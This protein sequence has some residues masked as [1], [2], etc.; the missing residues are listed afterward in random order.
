M[1]ILR[2]F[3]IS[4]LHDRLFTVF[5]GEFADEW[6]PVFVLTA[7]SADCFKAILH[8]IANPGCRWIVNKIKVTL[9]I[10]AFQLN[11]AFAGYGPGPE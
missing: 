9:E 6:P 2:Y 10:W 5:L 11:D 7:L 4:A 8:R 3:D 1:A